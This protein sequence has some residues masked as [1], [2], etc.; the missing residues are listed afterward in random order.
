VFLLSST[1]A[2]LISDGGTW[3]DSLTPFRNLYSDN[4][5]AGK[6]IGRLFVNDVYPDFQ[7]SKSQTSKNG[8]AAGIT[9]YAFTSIGI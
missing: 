4:A 1:V 7:L 3:P 9:E 6:E 8:H 5:T 2:D